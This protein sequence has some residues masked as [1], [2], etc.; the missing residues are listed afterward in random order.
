M[1]FG[2]E[3]WTMTALACATLHDLRLHLDSVIAVETRQE[4]L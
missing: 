4:G 1:G 2:D 3:P